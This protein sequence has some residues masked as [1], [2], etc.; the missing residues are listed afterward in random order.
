MKFKAGC[1]PITS[2][3]YVGNVKKDGVWAPN[4]KDITKSAVS[5]VAQHLLQLNQKMQFSYNGKKYELLVRQINDKESEG[6]R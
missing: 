2:T 3:I 1:S 5:A 6:K 4:K